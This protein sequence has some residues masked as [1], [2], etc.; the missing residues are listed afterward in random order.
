MNCGQLEQHMNIINHLNRDNLIFAGEVAGGLVVGGATL[1][2]A[3]YGMQTI[4]QS[5]LDSQ[6]GEHA[7]GEALCTGGDY[8]FRAGKFTAYTVLV[9][10]D[11]FLH[12]IPKWTIMHGLPMAY[13]FSAELLSTSRIGILMGSEFLR[14]GEGTQTPLKFLSLRKPQFEELR[15][16]IAQK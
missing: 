15:L 5:L 4:G 13:K 14:L 9:P 7:L 16:I 1:A 6:E 3:G 12:R 10:A 11:I 2:L 8:T